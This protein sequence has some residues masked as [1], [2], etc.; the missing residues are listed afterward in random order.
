MYNCHQV[1]LKWNDMKKGLLDALYWR[2]HTFYLMNERKEAIQSLIMIEDELSKGKSILAEIGSIHFER[3]KAISSRIK[4]KS[5]SRL[6][7][8]GSDVAI[9]EEIS[10]EP[11]TIS[12]KEF[13][14]AILREKTHIY[15]AVGASP[16]SIIT[17]EVDVS[18]YGRIDIKFVENRVVK[19]LEV[20]M[21]ESTTSLV[22]QI[23]KYRVACELEMNL[24]LYDYVEAYVL[25]NSYGK[26]VL[27]EL[28]RSSVVILTH[29]GTPESVRRI[30]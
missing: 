14:E 6:V 17:T 25:A 20:K 8:Q 2:L 22:S 27:S 16:N 10:P 15:Q 5:F 30:M 19:I 21:G 26:F 11:Q 29:T 18:P 1:Y 23:D 28:T 3:F 13:C 9:V 24:G 7:G 4:D 12:E